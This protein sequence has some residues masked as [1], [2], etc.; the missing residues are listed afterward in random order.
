MRSKG[1]QEIVGFVLI[2]VLVMIAMMVF[3]VISIKH[4]PDRVKSVRVGNML[5]VIMKQ[6]T[7]CAIV[8]IPNYDNYE[9]LFKSC[10]K[11]EKCSNLGISACNYLNKSLRVVVGDMMKTDATISFYQ[12][13]F[14][15]KDSSGQKGILQFSNGNCTGV[16]ST[17]QRNIMSGSENL[18]VQMK[19]CSLTNKMTNS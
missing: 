5:D 9:D 12:I 1:Q 4:S 19:I 13:S 11:G 7:G 17:A 8:Y 3:L 2:V 15:S 16:S 18:I 14:S 10:Y 6:T